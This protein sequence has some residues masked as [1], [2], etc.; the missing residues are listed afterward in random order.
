MNSN[1][2]VSFFALFIGTFI[3]VLVILKFGEPIPI[4]IALI[5]MI[6]FGGKM[7]LG[8]FNPA[9][10]TGLYLRH[11]LNTTEYLVYIVAQILGAVAAFHVY[12]YT[13]VKSES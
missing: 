2:W 11:E 12:N 1:N 5:A 9:V 3:F 10:A 13:A 4:G 6:Y 8:A 7:S